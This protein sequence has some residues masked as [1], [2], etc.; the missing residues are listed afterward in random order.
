MN[1]FDCPSHDVMAS[2]IPVP[3]RAPDRPSQPLPR[4]TK[5]V[6]VGDREIPLTR[7]E[8]KRVLRKL[9]SLKLAEGSVDLATPAR[10]RNRRNAS[11]D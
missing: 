7:G 6:R 8:R 3:E 5:L 11:V 9:M 4:G 1:K 10:H 2:H